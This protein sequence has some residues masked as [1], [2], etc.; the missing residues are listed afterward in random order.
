MNNPPEMDNAYWT[1]LKNNNSI[2]NCN[3]KKKSRKMWTF[4]DPKGNKYQKDYILINNKWRNSVT[5]AEAYSTFASVGSDHRP[6]SASIRLGLRISKQP[7]A[8]VKYDWSM[9]RQDKNLQERYTVE[10]RN[11]YSILLIEEDSQTEKYGKFVS[12]T[13]EAAKECIPT[14]PKTKKPYLS[15]FNELKDA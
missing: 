2:C 12:A 7:A 5:N 11:R 14:I 4:I 9:L 13:K 1:L 8:T 10:V 15:D 6:V 3:C